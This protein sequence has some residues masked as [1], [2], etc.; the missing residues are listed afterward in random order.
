MGGA[1]S[2]G[3]FR[4][5][6]GYADLQGTVVDIPRAGIP[7]F[8][9]GKS[10]DRWMRR[11]FPDVRRCKSLSIV[12]KTSTNYTGYYISFGKSNARG[13]SRFAKGHKAPF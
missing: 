1:S 13:N 6:N 11:D 7:G 10:A 4:I 12:A 3:S 5:A 8:I 9:R 2:S